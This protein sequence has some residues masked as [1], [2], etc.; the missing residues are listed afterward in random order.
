MLRTIGYSS[1]VTT[2]FILAFAA[3]FVLIVGLIARLPF[4]TANHTAVSINADFSSFHWNLD[5]AR[6]ID[7]RDMSVSQQ[8]S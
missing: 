2:R 7:Q 8:R 6:A 1:V 3:M 5:W 4:H